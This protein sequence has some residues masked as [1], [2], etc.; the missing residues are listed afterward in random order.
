MI[1]AAAQSKMWFNSFDVALVLVLGFGFWRGRKNGMT[2]EFLPVSTWLTIVF[3][4]GLL[5]EPLGNWLMH[6]GIVKR[7]FGSSFNERTA[8]YLTTY[9]FIALTVWLIFYVIKKYLKPKLEGS[10]IFGAGEYYLGMTS[11][12]I[13][14]ACITLFALAL[15]DA[16]YYSSA[17]ISAQK[18]YNNRWY[19]GG[20]EG[21]SGDF[22]PSIHDAQMACFRDSRLGPLIKSGV[23]MLLIDTSP[24]AKP[25]VVSFQ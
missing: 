6:T 14:Y 11:G 15:L 12:V 17:E 8:A 24:T 3:A 25:P 19:G 23:G 10:N 2:K 21:Y 22:I 4:A 18:A 13:R 9:L 7:V 5:H 1:L 16:P 20:M